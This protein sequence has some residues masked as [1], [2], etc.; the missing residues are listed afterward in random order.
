MCVSVYVCVC[1]SVY[2]SVCGCVCVCS[3]HDS[4]WR[5][6]SKMH[7]SVS[8]TAEMMILFFNILASIKSS[9]SSRIN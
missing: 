7:F 2:V 4:W 9:S 1:V 8:F 3:C 5:E 6:F